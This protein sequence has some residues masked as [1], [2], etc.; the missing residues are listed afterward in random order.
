MNNEC[1]PP[2]SEVSHCHRKSSQFFFILSGKTADQGK[3]W[4][5]RVPEAWPR[6]LECHVVHADLRKKRG[7]PRRSPVSNQ[8][9]EKLADQILNAREAVETGPRIADSRRP[10]EHDSAFEPNVVR[11]RFCAL[12]GRGTATEDLEEQ[13][14]EERLIATMSGTLFALFEKRRIDM[15]IRD[16]QEFLRYFGKIHQRTMNVVGAIPSGKVDWGFRPD[17]RSG[18][19]HCGIEWIH[20]SRSCER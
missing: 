20:F 16:P 18:A 10:S 7:N 8:P 1:M 4:T 13:R 15:E 12:A 5:R 19:P 6:T 2:R 14:G 9:G 17:R 11:Q 3:T